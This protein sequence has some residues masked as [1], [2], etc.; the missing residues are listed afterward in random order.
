MHTRSTRAFGRPLLLMTLTLAV[1]FPSSLLSGAQPSPEGPLDVEACVRIALD[2]SPLY[3]AAQEGVVAAREAVGISRSAYY[4]EVGLDARYR[5]F[6]THAFLPQGL[7]APS[8]TLGAT[9]D[10][11]AGLKASWTLFDSGLRRAEVG[12][13]TAGQAATE[14]DA[15]RVRQDVVLAVQEAYY[16]L[17]AAQAA[18]EAVEARVVRSRDHARLAQAR[19]AAGASPQAEVLRARVE[20]AD[21]ELGLVRAEGNAQI[22]RGALSMAMGLPVDL[23]VAI[24]GDEPSPGPEPPAVAASLERARE[25]RPEVKA[26]RQ[27]VAAASSAVAGAKALFGPRLRAE[28]AFGWRDDQFLPVDKDWSIGLAVQIPVFNGFASTHRINKAVSE[29]ASKEL[30]LAQLQ[31]RIALEVWTALARLTEAR[32]AVTQADELRKEAVETLRFARARYEAGA[33]SITDLLDSE[34]TLTQAESGFVQ[35]VL[36]LQLAGA[37]LRWAEGDL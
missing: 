15:T 31:A 25:Q 2:K 28:G 34:A 9:N 21:A 6:D 32:Q 4:P 10:W 13:A 3:R 26:F 5:L 11:S 36:G 20:V 8:T 24:K 23:D 14:E 29:A 22:A 27:K 1:T 18:G 17:L 12:V 19:K 33:S 35:S 30:E 16:N 37:R 7:T